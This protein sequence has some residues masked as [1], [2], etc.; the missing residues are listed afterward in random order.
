[1]IIRTLTHHDDGQDYTLDI[2]TNGSVTLT[3]DGVWAGN[4]RVS[5]RRIE[6]AADIHDEVYEALERAMEGES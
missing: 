5:G 2:L 3:V 1:M 4:G 6:C